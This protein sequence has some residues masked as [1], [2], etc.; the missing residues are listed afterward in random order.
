MMTWFI[1]LGK[2]LMVLTF[3]IVLIYLVV[4]EFFP[5]FD[6]RIPITFA[7]FAT[8]IFTAY[9]FLPAIVRVYR[10]FTMPDHIPLYCITPDGYA[11]DPLN[12]GVIGTKK[13]IIEAMTEAGW[14]MADRRTI[15]NVLKMAISVVTRRPYLTAPFSSLFLFGRKQ[16]LGFQRPAG[17]SP[18]HRHHVRFWA[19]HLDGPEAFHGDVHFWKRLHRPTHNSDDRQLWVGAASKDTG[20]IPIRHNAQLT[21]MID[22]DTDAERD[23]IVEGLRSSHNV[24]HTKTIKV[25]A[26]Y[27]LRNRT[28]GG[29]LRTDGRMRI[30]ILKD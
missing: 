26:A 28:I 25:G 4:W 13:Q 21:H 5:F 23:L 1:R 29:I 16:D 12:V 20:I 10:L 8:Y 17:N 2:R 22:P 9:F 24:A 3:G 30:C 11:S 6:N 18:S 14:Y 27:E 7:L 19:C 15:R